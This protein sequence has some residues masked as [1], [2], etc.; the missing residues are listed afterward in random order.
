MPLSSATL[1]S[2][3]AAA[4][5]AADPRLTLRPFL[6][7]PAIPASRNFALLAIGKASLEMAEQAVQIL[8]ARIRSGVVTCVP[9]RLDRLDPAAHARFADARTTLLPADH[10]L[11]TDRNVHAARAVRDFVQSLAPTDHLLVLLSGGG[12]AHLALPAD[13]LTLDALRDCTRRLQRAGRDIRELNCVRKHCEQLKGGRLA[14][15]CAAAAIT[16]LVLSDVLGD[17]LDVISSGPFAPDPTTFAQALNIL[18]QS[19]GRAS[20][21]SITNHLESGA[22][23]VLPETPKPGDPVFDRVHTTVIGSNDRV[24][25]ALAAHARSV[26]APVATVLRAIEVEARDLAATIARRARSMQPSEILLVG[27]EWTVHAGETRGTGGPSQELALALAIELAGTPFQALVYSTDGID[28]PTDA[29]GAIVHGQT[30]AQ[31]RTQALDAARSLAAHDS[32]G[33]FS[34]LPAQ[35]G[36]LIR[37]GPTG[38]NLN[39]VAVILRQ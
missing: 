12:S 32:H 9:Q 18:D 29:A 27:G 11:P 2:F 19:I 36:E 1:R 38:T 14:A 25:D 28:G 6:E 4:Q 15:H 30:I 10:P 33:F 34:R 35:A 13:G 24:L 17:P 22:C 31:A 20:V 5:Q 26:G 3:L 37:T 39:H 8:G 16:V 7:T 21:P 23:G